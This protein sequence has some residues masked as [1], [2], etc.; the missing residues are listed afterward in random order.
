MIYKFRSKAAGDV[1]MTASVG[2]RVL[3]AMGREPGPQGIFEAESLRSL[4]HA[5]E[6]AIAADEAQR[7]GS[8]EAEGARPDGAGAGDRVSLKQRAWPLM[9]MM[10][11]A[12]A[13][14]QDIV[15]GV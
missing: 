14:K 4:I 15:W 2:D 1:I 11:R 12:D 8:T 10:K 5:M 13:A 9:E 6:I 3:R 7:A